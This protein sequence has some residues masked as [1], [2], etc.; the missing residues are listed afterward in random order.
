MRV[1]Q[2][3]S[4][5]GGGGGF[6]RGSCSLLAIRVTVHLQQSFDAD[7][8][9]DDGHD[10]TGVVRFSSPFS[11]RQATLRLPLPERLVRDTKCAGERP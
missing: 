3:A 8:V 9:S 6:G 5:T 4:R 10:P 2:R 11:A 7:H 1:S